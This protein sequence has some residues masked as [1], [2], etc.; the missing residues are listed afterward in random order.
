MS[1][2]VAGEREH[3][4]PV[5]YADLGP[6]PG[7]AGDVDPGMAYFARWK[8]RPSEPSEGQGELNVVPYL[9]IMMNLIMFM[10]LSVTG[11]V[12]LGMIP[13]TLW[14]SRP[15]PSTRAA[16]QAISVT[17]SERDGFLVDGWGAS[18][19]ISKRG[20]AYDYRA[21]TDVLR[22]FKAEVPNATRVVVAADPG[23]EYAVLVHTLDA[24]RETAD[25]RPLFFDVALAQR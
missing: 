19:R 12:V 9:D 22:E 23:V 13:A 10:L 18:E 5:H 15:M 8:L 3:D 6:E 16:P 24:A 11:F 1:G 25:H 20:A 14:T 17:I 21:L 7:R 4:A 2:G